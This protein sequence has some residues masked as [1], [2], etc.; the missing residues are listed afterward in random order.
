MIRPLPLPEMI[1]RNKS[2]RTVA[3]NLKNMSDHADSRHFG[4]GDPV[5]V[6]FDKPDGMLGRLGYVH[7]SRRSILHRM[8]YIGWTLTVALETERSLAST[9]QEC[10]K[11]RRAASVSYDTLPTLLLLFVVLKLWGDRLR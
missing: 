6:W 5:G 1:Y 3:S 4:R 2:L 9:L 10:T 8:A 11:M 7:P